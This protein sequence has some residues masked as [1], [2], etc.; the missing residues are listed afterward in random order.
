MV[1][2]VIFLFGLAVGSFLNAFIY[3]LEVQQKLR[4]V[5]HDREKV[6][7][8]VMRGRSFCPSC[9]HT[10][11][12]QDLIPLL[13]FA[14]LKGRC[15]YCKEKISFQYPLIE[16][17]TGLLFV[18]V[19][20]FVLPELSLVIPTLTKLSFPQA[21]Q[22]AYLWTIASLLTVIFVYDLKHFVIPDKVLYP[23]ILVVGMWYLVS[24]VLFDAYTYYQLL[25]TFYSALGAAGFFLAIYLLSKGRAMGFGDVKLAFFMGLF[26]SWPNILVAMSL[27]FGIG[28]I[29]GLT[30]IF[31]KRK[32]MRS[33]VPFGPFLILGTLVALFWGEQLVYFYISLLGV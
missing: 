7:V 5:P 20:W 9:S 13:S 23:A 33:E 27:A 4:P 8:T 29:V 18:A 12:W 10:L 6:G 17:A 21:A 1:S 15:R 30:L 26:L 28:A 31:L 32:T 24:S 22:L 2:F 3:R 11:A 25:I 14:L 16:L 19:L